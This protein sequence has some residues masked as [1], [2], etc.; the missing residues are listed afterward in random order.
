MSTDVF[1]AQASRLAHH[2]SDK[3]GIK[4]KHGSVL[5]AIASV[6][7]VRDWNTLRASASIA[8]P[9]VASHYVPTH[10]PIPP[11]PVHIPHALVIGAQDVGAAVLLEQMAVQHVGEGGGLLYFSPQPDPNLDQVLQHAADEAEHKP[12]F[13]SLTPPEPEGV[14]ACLP[15]LEA[16]AQSGY[17]MHVSPVPGATAAATHAGTCLMLRQLNAVLTGL[18]PGM[19]AQSTMP[20]MVVLPAERF[21]LSWLSLLRQGQAL[22]VTFVLQADSPSD[23]DRIG[24]VFLNTITRNVGTQLMLMPTTELGLA[25]TVSHIMGMATVSQQHVKSVLSRMGPGQAL[26]MR[27]GVLEAIRYD[28]LSDDVTILGRAL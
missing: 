10:S 22:G 3:H 14:E 6:H 27:G 24:L 15:R 1:K 28:G 8:S 2:L 13:L 5:E 17:V 4:L 21:D 19:H 20:L 16:L 9:A 25:R 23:L 11:A 18:T 12:Q 7:G 26:R